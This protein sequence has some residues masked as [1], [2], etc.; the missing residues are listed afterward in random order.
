MQSFLHKNFSKELKTY[1]FRILPKHKGF[2]RQLYLLLWKA[3]K[4]WKKEATSIQDSGFFE[5]TDLK[6]GTGFE[7]IPKEIQGSLQE[8]SFFKK[9]YSYVQFDRTFHIEMV[10]PIPKDHHATS[11]LKQTVHKFFEKSL[12]KI[13][14]WLFIAGHFASAHCSKNVNIYF[15]FTEHKKRL[16]EEKE[17]FG[18][19]HANTAFT[20]VCSPSTDIHIFRKEEWFKVFIHETFHNLGMD[21]ATMDVA[22]MDKMIGKVFHIR[23]DFRVYETYCEV[24]A[25]ILSCLL[26]SYFE[27]DGSREHIFRYMEKCITQESIFAVFQ[28]VKVLD[29]YGLTYDKLVESKSIIEYQDNTYVFS[30]YVLKSILLF[31][32]SE[33]LDFCIEKNDGMNFRK[34]KKTV[35]D[36]GKLIISLS[37]RAD[38]MEMIHKAEHVLKHVPLD[39]EIRETMRMT[40]GTYGHPNPQSGF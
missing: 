17:P 22:D 11:Y 16:P 25:V 9:T 29:H 39:K 23:K 32:I 6:K 27:T 10:Y 7:W 26:E 24:W 40:Q 12:Y 18:E 14:I 35:L 21:F 15:Y 4:S 33:F 20:T 8:S 38:Y 37:K 31:H 34:T 19:I 36:Y 13:Y 28:A 1:E 30:Y 5:T 3:E 2:L